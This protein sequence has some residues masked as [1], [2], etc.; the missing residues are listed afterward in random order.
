MLK[1]SC[2]PAFSSSWWAH[3]LPLSS[4]LGWFAVGRLAW[5]GSVGLRVRP[6]GSGPLCEFVSPLLCLYRWGVSYVRQQAFF[7]SLLASIFE[8][9]VRR[10]IIVDTQTR[11]NVKF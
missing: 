5:P 10:G 2:C 6:S 9:Q 3:P 11:G 7:S 8:Y 1:G 4:P